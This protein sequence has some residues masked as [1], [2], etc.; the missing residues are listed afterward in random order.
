[1]TVGEFHADAVVE[2]CVDCATLWTVVERV[3]EEEKQKDWAGS[4]VRYE[5]RRC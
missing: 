2:V 1:M 5:T 4:G 3:G